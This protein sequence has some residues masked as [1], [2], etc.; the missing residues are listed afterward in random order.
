M[1]LLENTLFKNKCSEFAFAKNVFSEDE[2][3]K[4]IELGLARKSTK[5]K[6]GGEK[7][8]RNEK[9]RKGKTSW[10][11][12]CED[13]EWLFRKLTDLI[14]KANEDY[15]GFELHGMLEPLQFTIYDGRK[16][17][18]TA[19]VDTAKNAPTRKLSVVIQLSD[20]SEYKG[21]RLKLYTDSLK[22]K[23]IEKEKGYV[24]FFPS[25]VLHEVTP[26]TKGTRYSLVVWVHGPDFK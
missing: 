6:I 3:K 17:K 5:A 9:I 14:N 25:Y 21:G 22:A 1:W 23:K 13:S 15:F 20:P 16:T 12:P 8:N 19:H 24:T 11:E 18:Y 7:N 2:I 10:I 4:I 26:V